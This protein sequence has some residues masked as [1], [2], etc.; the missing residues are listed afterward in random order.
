MVI[1][2]RAGLFFCKFTF[3]K[4]LDSNWPRNLWM[5]LLWTSVLLNTGVGRLQQLSRKSPEDDG[6]SR[7]SWR[8][9][10]QCFV[11]SAICPSTGN[12]SLHYKTAV[13]QKGFS[14]TSRSDIMY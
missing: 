14:A 5:S 8:G 6:R 10:G 4:L 3:I 2:K 1:L 9:D 7:I 13:L 11:V 12:V